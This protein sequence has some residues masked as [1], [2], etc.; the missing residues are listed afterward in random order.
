MKTRGPEMSFLTSRR[1][2]WQ[3]E[4][5]KSSIPATS[6]APGRTGSQGEGDDLCELS[7]ILLAQKL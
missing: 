1:R 6:I 3:K 5:W 2:F 4:Q 7:G